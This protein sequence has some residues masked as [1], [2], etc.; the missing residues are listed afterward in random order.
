MNMRT[1]SSPLYPPLV[2]FTTSTTVSFPNF[3]E[4]RTATS[5]L[6]QPKPS[7]YKAPETNLR[8]ATSPLS[9]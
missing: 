3:N 1:A 4:F 5:P 7:P 2:D 8:T 6:L 9:C